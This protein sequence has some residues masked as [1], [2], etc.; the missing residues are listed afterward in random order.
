MSC[1]DAF[2]DY[3]VQ[4]SETI[5]VFAQLEPLT[6]YSWVITDKFD[7]KYSGLFNTDAD[8]FWAI[9]VDALPP[10]LLTEYS[11]VFTLEV[12]DEGCKPIK[13]KI[14]QEYSE[15]RFSIKAGT[16]EK[17]ILGCDFS[18]IGRTGAQSELVT[19]ED[20]LTVELPWTTERATIYG[21]APVIQV[22]H[23]LS[24]DTYQLASVSI[25][26]NY[27]NNVLDSITVNNGGVASGYVLIR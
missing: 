2:T 13:F 25:Q 11:G 24:G 17:N 9:D 12:Q 18:C 27:V 10:G 15:I 14:A 3:L 23:L 22:Y 21:N 20:L 19:F 8:G 4:C 26:Q 1:S 7:H 16:M 6:S 5:D